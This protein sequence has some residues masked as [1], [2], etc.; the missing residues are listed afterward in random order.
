VVLLL[1]V[2]SD[3]TVVV[4][5]TVD[6]EDDAIVGVGQGLSTRLCTRRLIG[7]IFRDRRMV[8]LTNTDNAKTLMAED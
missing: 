8:S 5:L 1:E 7:R 6:G 3:Q 2:S 4:N